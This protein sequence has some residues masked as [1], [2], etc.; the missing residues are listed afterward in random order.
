MT[1]NKLSDLFF[2]EECPLSEKIEHFLSEKSDDDIIKLYNIEIN[3]DKNN[4]ENITKMISE[5]DFKI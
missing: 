4:L 2:D 1:Y 3:T 5:S